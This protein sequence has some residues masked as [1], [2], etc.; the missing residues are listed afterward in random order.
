MASTPVRM[1]KNYDKPLSKT[2]MAEVLPSIT[3][4]TFH[5]VKSWSINLNVS[6]NPSMNRPFQTDGEVLEA[7]KALI[8]KYEKGGNIVDGV[9]P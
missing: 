2:T 3:T 7:W 4:T 1:S 5:F 8:D 9:G 6:V